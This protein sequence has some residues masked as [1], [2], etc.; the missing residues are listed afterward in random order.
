MHWYLF[1]T[2][3]KNNQQYVM[4]VNVFPQRNIHISLTWFQLRVA[5]ASWNSE[6]KIQQVRK[7]EMSDLLTFE[8]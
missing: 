5:I 3:F 4:S 1:L 6:L 8:S 7:V 2:D